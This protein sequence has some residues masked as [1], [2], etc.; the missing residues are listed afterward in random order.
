MFG[1]A[2]LMVST[3]LG[4]EARGVV[5]GWEQVVSSNTDKT[6]HVYKV[7][8]RFTDAAGKQHKGSY[9]QKA[10][11]RTKLANEGTVVKVRYLSAFPA[12]HGLEGKN[13]L[14]ALLLMGAGLVV[15]FV[16]LKY[17]PKQQAG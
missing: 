8:Y 4:S 15:G 6:D 7:A 5:T 11:N 2:K 16:A 12:I 10:Y 1:V 14:Q 9:Q 17:Q 13:P 3:P